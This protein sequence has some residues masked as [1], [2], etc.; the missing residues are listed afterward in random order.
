MAENEILRCLQCARLTLQDYGWSNYTVEG[1]TMKCQ[2]NQFEDLDEE[3]ENKIFEKAK[4][5][6]YYLLGEP[7]QLYVD[8]ED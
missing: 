1:T 4:T 3:E 7:L 2:A 8:E 5:C 6:K